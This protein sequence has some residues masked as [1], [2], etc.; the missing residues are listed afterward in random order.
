MSG[1]YYNFTYKKFFIVHDEKIRKLYK[2]ILT[3]E[4]LWLQLLF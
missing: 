3:K 2:W 4:K 1:E